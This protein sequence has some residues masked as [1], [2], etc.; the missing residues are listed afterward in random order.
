MDISCIWILEFYR[1][2]IEFSLENKIV[3][4]IEKLIEKIGKFIIRLGTDMSGWQYEP[5]R[6][7]RM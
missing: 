4:L 6:R 7:E 5:L 1:V 3:N 2:I